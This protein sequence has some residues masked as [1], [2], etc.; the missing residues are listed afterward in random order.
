M[1]KSI[2]ECIKGTQENYIL[3]FLWLHGEDEETLRSYMAAIYKANIRAVCLE[4]RPHPD[5]LGPRWWHDLDIILEEA[6][7]RNMKV[8]IL[9]DRHY[10]TG[11]AAGAVQAAPVELQKQYLACNMADICGPQRRV[12]LDIGKMASTPRNPMDPKPPAYEDDRLLAVAA[13]R[14]DGPIDRSLNHVEEVVVLTE[15]VRDGWMVWDV[16]KGMWRVFTFYITH[17]GGTPHYINLVDSASCKVLLDTV[18]EAHFTHYADEFGTTI[19]GF[20]SD[21]PNL[22]N[23]VGNSQG[24]IVGQTRMSLPWSGEME[25]ALKDIW[26]ENYGINLPALWGELGTPERTAVIRREFMDVLTDLVKRCFSEQI[27][28]WCRDHGVEYIGHIIEDNNASEGLGSSVGHYFRGLWGQDMAGIDD[29]GAQITVGGANV[30]HISVAGL[31]DGE[32]YHHVLGKLGSSLA[33]IDPKKKDRCV[34]ECFG[35]YGWSEGT[36]TMKYIADHLLADGVNHF[37]PHAF[38]AKAFPDFDCPPHFYAGGEDILFPAFGRLMAYMNRT[39]HILSAYRHTAPIAVLYHAEAAWSGGRF[40]KMQKC[41]RVLREHQID[42]DIL[43][44]ETLNLEDNVLAVN[45][46]TYKALVIPGC[47]YPGEEA[48]KFCKAAKEAGFPVYFSD[49]APE[50]AEGEAVPLQELAGILADTADLTLTPG[51]DGIR[52][53]HGVREGEGHVYFLFNTSPWSPFE[54]TMN[55]KAAGHCYRY[56]PMENR[57]YSRE[58]NDGSLQVCLKPMESALFVVTDE[59][60]EAEKELPKLTGSVPLT[61]KWTVSL[62]EN[63]IFVPYTI[64]DSLDGIMKDGWSGKIRYEY[65]IPEGTVPA[66]IGHIVLRL[67]QVRETAA[68]WCN[69]EY[70]G[71]AIAAPFCFNLT[72]AWNEGKNCLQIDVTSTMEQKVKAVSGGRDWFIFMQKAWYG[73]GLADVPVLEYCLAGGRRSEGFRGLH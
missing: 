24:C 4:S 52:I 54:G 2:D 30:E 7:K 41:A 65:Q 36:Q 69:G 44:L 49:F 16:P 64:T 58:L 62:Q 57:I 8:W 26:G 25:A 72:D 11:S 40:T 70:T 9:D 46:R 37:V 5:F 31:G 19:A 3:P 6:K 20:F 32:F 45:G 55:V 14:L 71:D 59:V 67:P 22:G 56:D 53:Y 66:D 51:H 28:D 35:A 34:C 33:H 18:Y 61:G 1:L 73:Y 43:P 13:A 68:V 23:T 10:P 12:R 50:G 48:V 21:E 38:S 39:A 42:F 15:E 60:I 27:G 17:N 63:G 47:E 29:I